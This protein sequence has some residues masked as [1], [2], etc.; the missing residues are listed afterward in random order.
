MQAESTPKGGVV[1]LGD[2]IIEMYSLGD[3]FED[4]NYINRGI[5]S[6]ETAQVL[7]RLKT[8]VIDIAP[9]VVLIHVGANDIGHNVPKQ[10]YLSNMDKI[11]KTLKSN[12][13]NAKILVDCIYPTVTLGNIQSKMLTKDRKNA[14]IIDINKN[15]RNVCA[16]NSVEFIDSFNLLLENDA[17]NPKYTIDGLHLNSKGYRVVSREIIKYL[18]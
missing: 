16:V 3:F 15:L 11:I 18:V 9:S 8:N 7:D 14:T 17:L 10:T 6:N 1:F 2:S 5:S 12:L 13:P 4:K